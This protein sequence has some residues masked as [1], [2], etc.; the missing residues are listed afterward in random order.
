MIQQSKPARWLP[1]L[2]RVLLFCLGSATVLATVSRFTQ[3]FPKA[4]SDHLTI[5]LA[6]ILTFGLTLLFLRWEGLDLG[7][8]GLIP[9]SQ[10]I[11]RMATGFLIGLILASLQVGAVILFGHLK[12]VLYPTLSFHYILS[13][14]LLYLLIASREELAFRAYP[15]RGLNYVIGPWPAQL[16][17]AVI[18][19]LEHVVGGMTWI[20]AFLGSGMGAILFGVAALRTKGVALPIGLHAAWNFGQWVFGFKNV[21]GIWEAIV[22]KGY[23]PRVMH[24]GMISYIFIMSLAIVIFYRFP[25]RNNAE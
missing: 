14:F 22:E 7:D 9:G 3:G 24:T 19:S 15:L 10:S 18:F 5:L 1:T 16:I 17:V 12:L 11:S 4:W 20:Q 23:G 13:A 21:P 25:A 2:V 6:I 8:V